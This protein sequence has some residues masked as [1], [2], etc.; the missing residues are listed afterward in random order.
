MEEIN[1][2]IT[3]IKTEKSAGKDETFPK[4]FKY[5]GVRTKHDPQLSLTIYEDEDF[6]NIQKQ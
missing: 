1:S 6:K 4:L 3:K 5:C 2:T